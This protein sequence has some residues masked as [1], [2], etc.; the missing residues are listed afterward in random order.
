[1]AVVVANLVSPVLVGRGAELELLTS[2]LEGM[3]DGR[4]GTVLVG[5]EAGVGKSRL[6]AELTHQARTRGARALVGG[7]VELDGG[8]IPFA[9]LVDMLRA[10]A[11]E[12]ES[13]E[14]E[15]L[16]GPARGEIGRLVPELNDDE[17]PVAH[18][19]DP[20]RTL[21]LVLGVISRLA[22][23]APLMLVFED[24]QWADRAT[25]DLISLLAAG[26]SSRP[27]ML[28]FAVR[29]DE[30][31]RRHPFRRVAARWEQQRTV[32][33]VELER[34]SESEVSE[35]ITAI[36]GHRPDS[37]L[38]DLV[39]ERS[40]GIPLFVEELLG[41]VQQ[42]GVD[43]D[44]LPPSLRDAL[45]ARAES[46]P[47]GAQQL[48]RVVSA[49][50][51][52]VGEELL[53]TVSELP[54]DEL[55]S[56]LRAA[57]EHQLLVVD[58]SGRGYGF[59]HA[60][61]RAAVHEDLLPGERARLHRLF[62]EA[63]E[64]QAGPDVATLDSSSMLAYHWLA[65]H[66]VARALPASVRAG[67]AA[68]AASA[69]AAAQRHFELA[70]E[71]WSQVPEAAE[72]VG[73]DHP[74]LLEA[75]ADAAHRA[76]AVDRAL[77]LIDEALAEVDDA[78]EGERRALLIVQRVAILRDLGR[79]EEGL[80][81][82]EQ[83]VE[84]LSPDL[85]SRAAVL[86]QGAL[87]RSLLRLNLMT[88]AGEVAR[89]ALDAAEALG[90]I[91]AKL[92]AQIT[93]GTAIGYGGDPNDGV[94]LVQAAGDEAA[95]AGLSW[96]A[97]RAYV[98]LSDLLIMLS[99]YDEAVQTVDRGLEMAEEAG[100]LR[101]VGAFLRGNRAEAMFRTGRWAQALRGAAPETGSSG[102][103]AAAASIL[104]AE[105]HVLAGRPDEAETDL[106]LTRRELRNTSAAQFALPIAWVEAELA[107]DRGDLVQAQETLEQALARNRDPDDER[108]RWPALS[109]LA[110][111]AAD[112]AQQARDAHSSVPE[113]AARAVEEVVAEAGAM[114]AHTPA[115]VGHRALVHAEQ[116]R[117]AGD[118]HAVWV[119]AVER[120]RAM[121]EPIV[122]AYALFRLAEQQS[123]RGEM[124]A[125]QDTAAEALAL[126]QSIGAAPLVG[127][128]TALVRRARLGPRTGA[129][130]DTPAPA[131]AGP[132]RQDNPYELT[133]R[134]REVLAL[135]AAGQSNGD[136]AETLFISRKTASVHVSNILSKL[137]VATR[138]QAAAVAHRRGL[139]E[140]GTD[141]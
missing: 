20:E 99:R 82:L 73:M 137:G 139:V 16:L 38:I 43:R 13:E 100:L 87:S 18:E 78:P 94:P 58:P 50:G 3:M 66:D 138:V 130:S 89:R 64:A 32:T 77:A 55:Y 125:A 95:R 39:F 96:V 84:M 9:P 114:A 122:L 113:D 88:R 8:G 133:A 37:E 83:T 81:L 65:A 106:R 36:L 51:P 112:R 120:C 116:A 72:S 31:H 107:R 23:A 41:A 59:R 129:S 46:L 57:I 5:G 45:L 19:R 42:G 14:F 71:L 132:A 91:E 44:F 35:Q 136:I 124:P 12:L 28:V 79:D 115:D 67:R 98:N 22:A 2:T 118:E 97:T 7:C 75:A 110:R 109:L 62:A 63:L 11:R 131:N 68:A 17:A 101:T 27:L 126:A 70:V 47:P 141:G 111:I 86:V 135:V 52:W 69:P 56:A 26:R 121:N 128:I 30:L 10:L 15:S 117:L 34:L 60:L 6:I 1:M 92:D 80:A 53:S 93:V 85:P 134:E 119:E 103:Y 49:A 123:T 61:A 104:R 105:L 40:E 33:R 48:L 74:A 127:E 140:T 102:V 4:P 24:V 90:A 29:S 54:A 108:Y 25:L 76:G 21:E